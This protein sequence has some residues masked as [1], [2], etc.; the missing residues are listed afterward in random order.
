MPKTGCVV[1]R[2]CQ[3][4]MP[5]LLG[6]MSEVCPF[7]TTRKIPHTLG[8]VPTPICSPTR[9][10]QT[11]SNACMETYRR[12]L[13]KATNFV[14]CATLVGRKL[15]GASWLENLCVLHGGVYDT[16]YFSSPVPWQPDM[17]RAGDG[18][19][20]CLSLRDENTPTRHRPGQTTPI[21]G[22]AK[23]Q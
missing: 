15:L 4:R 14:V 2:F 17:H 6:A 18:G 11:Q 22:Q 8:R 19:G 10:A 3:Q 9:G 7:S 13:S 21:G 5:A 16:R 20:M 1:A 12:D 23:I